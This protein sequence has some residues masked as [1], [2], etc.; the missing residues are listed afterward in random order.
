MTL[1]EWLKQ[2]AAQLRK[3]PHPDRAR[4]DAELLLQ[5]L[6]H[7]E[8]AALLARSKERLAAGEAEI[9]VGLLDRRAAGEPIQ[10]ITGEAEFYSLPFRV[11][12]DVLIPR[13]ETEHLVEKVLECA[14]RF[15]EPSI[16]D[17]GCGSGAIAVA[18]AHNLPQAR[19]TATDVSPRALAVAKGNAVR[20]GVGDRI[21][22]M[23][24]NLL[25]AVPRE[26]FDI[27]A[28]NPP[29]VPEMDRA[30][31][32]VEVC[33]HEPAIA[34]FAGSDGLDVIRRL[35]PETH[36]IL[37]PGGFLVMEFGYGQW[38]AVSALLAETGFDRIEFVP[39]LRGIPR[40]A[41]GTKP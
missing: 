23:R 31:L 27:V 25:G 38:P 19:I 10:Y 34:L 3:G 6:L 7:R 33:D 20:N 16:V 2:G 29:Y 5:H 39:D 35:I 22:F 1:E 12:P 17:V 9:Y 30:T 28:S 8:R 26:Q 32:A 37:V 36:R 21:R 4:R 15:D 40:I 14:A 11:T 13:P 24:G 18:L 41:C